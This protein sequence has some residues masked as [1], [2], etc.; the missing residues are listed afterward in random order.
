VHGSLAGLETL[1]IGRSTIVGTPLAQLLIAESATVTVAHSKSRD[2]YAMSR[3][4]DILF[5]ARS[6]SGVIGSNR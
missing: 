3:R 5:A 1:V 2:L 4:A 6:L